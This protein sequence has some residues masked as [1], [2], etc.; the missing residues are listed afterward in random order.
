MEFDISKAK[1]IVELR[2]AEDVN[3]YLKAGW[4]LFS[5]A[6]MTT[7]SREYSSPV[8]KYALA[9]T[10]GDEPVHPKSY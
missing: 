4:T 10:T 1:A 9:W 3:R 5:N 8:I 7:D 2:T 6:S